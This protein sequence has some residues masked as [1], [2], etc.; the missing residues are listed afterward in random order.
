MR[1]DGRWT[2]HTPARCRGGVCVAVV[3][4]EE[5]LLE[6][7][8]GTLPDTRL[9]RVRQHPPHPAFPESA[10][11]HRQDVQG[12]GGTAL[13]GPLLHAQARAVRARR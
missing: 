13:R 11:H 7:P 3:A 10:D 8:R 4:L 2:V 12:H 6:A 5:P 9:A 1:G